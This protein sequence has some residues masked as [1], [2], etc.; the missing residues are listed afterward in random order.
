MV[1]LLDPFHT[2]LV[3]LPA[4]I[5]NGSPVLLSY[6]GTPIDRGRKFLD[7]R[8]ILGPGKTWEGLAIGALYG[9]IFAT[10]LASMTCSLTIL[11]GG[12][13][14]AIGALLGDMLAAF[15][16]RRIGLE[17]GAPAPLLDQLDFYA[18]ALLLLYAVGIVVHPYTAVLIAPLVLA[19]HRLTNIAANKLRLKPV[20]W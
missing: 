16:K 10:F 12:I 17:R 2:I 7:G 5:A 19:L 13:A 6:G 18:G 4:L 9:S 14:A 8:P 11:K 1:E 15:V 3:L 20:P